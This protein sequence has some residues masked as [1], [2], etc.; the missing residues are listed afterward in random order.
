M[1]LGAVNASA[2]TRQPSP[3]PGWRPVCVKPDAWP[4]ADRSLWEAACRPASITEEGGEAAALRPDSR[5]KIVKGYGA[6]LSFLAARGWLVTE[7]TPA[8]R[9]TRARLAAYFAAMEAL[10]RR[11]YSILGRF[12]E[13]RMALKAMAPR[14]NTAWILAPNG[15]TIRQILDPA[16]RAMTIPD[17]KVLFQW[18]LKLMDST[19]LEDPRRHGLVQFRDGLLIAMLAARGRRL[20]SMALLRL[21]QEFIRCGNGY[22]VELQPSQ[23]KTGKSDSFD[24]PARLSSY[25]DI[26]L[27]T[28]RPAL[29]RD[30]CHNAL[31]VGIDGR[32]LEAKGIQEMVCKRSKTRFGIAFGPHRFRHSIATTVPLLAPEVP[33]LASPL[34]GISKDTVQA[35][36]DR[37]SQVMAV[38]LFQEM[39]EN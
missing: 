30:H 35:H 8:Q 13:L 15:L 34:L 6:W 38:K 37:A 32:P 22:R 7:E 12:M 20:R 29:L 26:Y 39:L 14:V 33:G 16:P 28:V 27:Q 3:V 18:G 5:K 10:N 31:W 2:D 11:P 1:M 9:A 24:L 36:Y 19:K 23:V 25:I 21:G 17:A 4:K